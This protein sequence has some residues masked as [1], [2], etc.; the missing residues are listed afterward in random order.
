M[1][2]INTEN[3]IVPIGEFKAKAA[4]ILKDLKD[5]DGPLVVT[6]N[7]RAAAI[8]LSPRAFD[9]MRERNRILEAISEGIADA[10][11]GSLVEH[12]EIR[13]WLTSWGQAS[14]EESE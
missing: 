12:Q 7:G 14:K 3:S 2:A 1:K 13:S 6:Q 11:D 5:N 9:Q 4:R 10:E 8:M